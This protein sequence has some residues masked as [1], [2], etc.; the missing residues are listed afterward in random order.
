MQRHKY[1]GIMRW[2][3][4]IL[5]LWMPSWGWAETLKDLL[6][7]LNGKVVDFTAGVMDRGRERPYLDI[8]GV[9]GWYE[10]D[11]ALKPSELR[12]INEVCAP[13]TQP[14]PTCAITGK[15]ELD[16]S[17]GEIILYIFEVSEV[18]DKF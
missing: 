2:F 3:V 14:M 12:G 8:K 7:G 10:F 13:I 1:S 15:A 9:S 17:S 5:C 16:T 18:R 11:Y 4:L 6:D